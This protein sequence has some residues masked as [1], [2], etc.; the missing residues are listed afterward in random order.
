MFIC[1]LLIKFKGINFSYSLKRLQQGWSAVADAP[2]VQVCPFKDRESPLLAYVI[3]MTHSRGSCFVVFS[4]PKNPKTPYLCAGLEELWLGINFDPFE[5]TLWWEP[6]CPITATVSLCRAA[7]SGSCVDL[8]G[9]SRNVTREQVDFA[10]FSRKTRF[11][12]VCI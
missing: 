9:T 10:T 11:S 12:S 2:R 7:E 5:G 8:P 3:C 4:P 6:A 1:R